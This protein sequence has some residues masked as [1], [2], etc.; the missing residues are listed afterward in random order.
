MRQWWYNLPK[1]EQTKWY[2]KQQILPPGTKRRF[3]HVEYAEKTRHEVGHEERERYIYKPYTSFIADGIARGTP[4]EELEARWKNAVKNKTPHARNVGG[5]WLVA[6]FCG[7]VVDRI[8]THAQGHS[9]EMRKAVD[10]SS[11]LRDFQASGENK[12]QAY[13]GQCTALQSSIDALSMPQSTTKHL[14][15]PPPVF[16]ISTEIDDEVPHAVGCNTTLL[17]GGLAHDR[18]KLGPYAE[19]G[20]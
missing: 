2:Q 7:I 20:I 14:K 18:Q 11:S 9:T 13:L 1:D 10:S 8:H 15:K 6:D 5:E 19:A 16:P 4:L 3:D 17:R 12:V